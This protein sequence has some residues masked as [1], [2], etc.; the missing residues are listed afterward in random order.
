MRQSARL[1]VHRKSSVSPRRP[2]SRVQGLRKQLTIRGIILWTALLVALV[3]GTVKLWQKWSYERNKPPLYEEY[4]RAELALPQHDTNNAFG[5]GK[6]YLW[7]NNHVSGEC[8]NNASRG[9][10]LLRVCVQGLGWGNY[11]EDLIMNGQVAYSSRR[12]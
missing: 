11:L 7:V 8:L 4:H 3:Y 12:S 9:L 6:K 1:P 2:G 10:S 5:N